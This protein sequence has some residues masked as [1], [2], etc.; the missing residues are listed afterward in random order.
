M[1]HDTSYGWSPD[2]VMYLDQFNG[3]MHKC[4]SVGNKGGRLLRAFG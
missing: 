2:L 4:G 3:A 1:G